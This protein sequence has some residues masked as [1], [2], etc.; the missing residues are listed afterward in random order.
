VQGIGYA[1]VADVCL[2]GLHEPEAVYKTF[3]VC[4][5]PSADEYEAMYELA[6]HMPSRATNYL[7]PALAPLVRNT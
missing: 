3:E 7:Q 2:R 5:E 1:D 4:Y 6:A